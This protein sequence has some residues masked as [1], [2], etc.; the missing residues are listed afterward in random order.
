MKDYVKIMVLEMSKSGKTK[1]VAITNPVE[2][3]IRRDAIKG[4]TVHDNTLHI[5]YR[6]TLL[7]EVIYYVK[8]RDE[9]IEALINN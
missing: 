8:V 4:F 3:Y 1:S 6:T 7:R 9:D 5:S 2:E